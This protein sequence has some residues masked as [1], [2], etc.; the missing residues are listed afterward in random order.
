MKT[1][2]LINKIEDNTESLAKQEDN[3]IQ[4]YATTFKEGS[5]KIMIIPENA[6]SWDQITFME[7]TDEVSSNLEDLYIILNLLHE[8]LD[9]PIT[10]RID[11][12]LFVFRL[13]SD[14]Y[15]TQYLNFDDFKGW[16]IEDKPL[17]YT[18][19][20]V[21]VFEDRWSDRVTFIQSLKQI[22]TEDELKGAY[23]AVL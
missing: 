5:H 3:N 13:P 19:R 10:K 21:E 15:K 4:L 8:Y 16:R 12:K 2:E 14:G 22:A 18:Q 7:S 20:A 9:T 17:T 11:Q 23:D 1:K 6:T